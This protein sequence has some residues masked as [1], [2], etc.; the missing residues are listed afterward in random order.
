[1]LCVVLGVTPLLLYLAYERMTTKRP[2]FLTSVF[3][4]PTSASF[5][6]NTQHLL[7]LAATMSAPVS[8]N[9]IDLTVPL[10]DAQFDPYN[11]GYLLVGGG[12]GENKAGVANTIVW[13]GAT[14]VYRLEA[15]TV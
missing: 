6:G 2:T 3:T 13:Q 1:M 8:Y 5:L 15:Y 9:T 11:R 10:F 4:S 14:T 12:G 7:C